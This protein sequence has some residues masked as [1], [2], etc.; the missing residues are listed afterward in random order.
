MVWG[1]VVGMAAAQVIGMIWYSKVVL[2]KPWMK[3]TFPGKT[4]EQIA[5]LQKESMHSEIIVCLIS[6]VALMM[7]I[8]YVI[9]PY[10]GVKTLE[11]AVK[12]G[13]GMS[14]LAALIDVPHCAFSRRPLAGFVIDHLYNTLVYVIACLSFVY[15]K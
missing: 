1:A 11:M 5:Q 7:A 2:G 15:F 12:V 9:G 4:Y 14:L 8:N 13:L 10:L 3:A 6:Q